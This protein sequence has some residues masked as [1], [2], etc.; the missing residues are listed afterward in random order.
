VAAGYWNR[1]DDT[2]VVFQNWLEDTGEGP[3]LSAG[4]LGFM[5]SGELYVTGRV[6]DLIIIRGRNIYP[7]DVESVVHQAIPFTPPNG[8][9]AFLDTDGGQLC[10]VMEGDRGSLRAARHDAQGHAAVFVKVCSAVSREFDVAVGRII[11]IKPGTFPRTS[12]GKVRRRTCR[13]E[14]DRGTLEIV[15]SWRSPALRTGGVP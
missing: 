2:Q 5:D 6:K 7:Q 12:S 10:I 15:A 4:D 9:A 1:A 3:F 11:I 13:E 14:L 8:C